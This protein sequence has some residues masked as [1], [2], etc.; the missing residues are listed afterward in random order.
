MSGFNILVGYLLVSSS[1][2]S[3]STLYV[4]RNLRCG[5][6]VETY[7]KGS[8]VEGENPLLLTLSFFK[9]LPCTNVSGLAVRNLHRIST[10]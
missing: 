4:V 10:K 3:N 9:H 5:R 8:G 6:S 1:F 2:V 7:S